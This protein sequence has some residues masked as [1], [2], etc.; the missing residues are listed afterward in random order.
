VRAWLAK[1]DKLRLGDRE[2]A[3]KDLIDRIERELNR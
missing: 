1:N 2:W 3:V